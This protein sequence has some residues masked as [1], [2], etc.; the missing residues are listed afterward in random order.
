MSLRIATFNVHGWRDARWE[1]NAARVSALLREHAVDVVGLQEV[2]GGPLHAIAAEN[3][4]HVSRNVLGC[5][6]LSRFPIVAQGPLSTREG[7]RRRALRNRALCATLDVGGEALRLVV[8]HLDHVDE[9]RRLRELAAVRHGLR[10]LSPRPSLWLGDFNALTREDYSPRAW[11][12]IA[13]VRERNRWEAP[14]TQVTAQ[15]KSLGFTDCWEVAGRE[16]PVSTCRFDTRIDY[17]WADPALLS[18]WSVSRCRAI[19]SDAS[20]HRMVLLELEG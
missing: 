16:T 9:S 11:V 1:D 19:P 17:L 10:D 3:G 13:Q 8:L 18:R 12:Q 6:L 14:H 15:M 2:E 20:D 5:A 4:L 7:G